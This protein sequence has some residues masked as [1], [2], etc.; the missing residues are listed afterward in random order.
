VICGKRIDGM[1]YFLLS[2]MQRGKELLCKNVPCGDRISGMLF[3]F[4]LPSTG[5]EKELGWQLGMFEKECS[6]VMHFDIKKF[7]SQD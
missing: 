2:L 3:W 4:L 1:L 5:M 7:L 6:I